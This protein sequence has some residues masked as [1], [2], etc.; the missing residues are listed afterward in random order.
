MQDE[1]R[2]VGYLVK[3]KNGYLVKYKNIT[4]DVTDSIQ[5]LIE[6]TR[7]AVKKEL[8]QIDEETQR[9]L[10]IYS[11]IVGLLSKDAMPIA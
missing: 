5:S 11:Q 10:T 2:R 7:D 8:S 4:I 1:T 3:Y 9:K 6:E